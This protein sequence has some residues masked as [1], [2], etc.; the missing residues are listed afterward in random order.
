MENSNQVKALKTVLL[1]RLK[2]KQ[3]F[4]IIKPKLRGIITFPNFDG[5]KDWY[6]YVYT[7]TDYKGT[8]TEDCNEGDLVWVKKSEI[9]DI[10]NLGRR[11][12]LS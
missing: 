2:K 10:K 5:E 8:L 7:A 9:Q 1:E 12:H 11:L 6:T 4:D 3:T